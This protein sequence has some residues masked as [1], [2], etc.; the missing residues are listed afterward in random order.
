MPRQKVLRCHQDE[1]RPCQIKTQKGLRRLRNGVSGRSRSIP[2]DFLKN[3]PVHFEVVPLCW[4][5]W[6]PS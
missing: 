3:I 5:V 2:Q 1:G 6:Q 4:T